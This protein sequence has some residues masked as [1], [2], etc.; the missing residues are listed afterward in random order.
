MTVLGSCGNTIY[1]IHSDLEGFYF[2][3]VDSSGLHL[4][5]LLIKKVFSMK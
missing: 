4:L 1:H 5:L 2:L 3:C